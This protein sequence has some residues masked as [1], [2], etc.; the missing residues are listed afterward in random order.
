MRFFCLI[1][2]F[3]LVTY[4]FPIS[5]L[6]D[7]LVCRNLFYL[8]LS[9]YCSWLPSVVS[10]EYLINRTWNMGSFILIHWILNLVFV[11]LS[12]H[13]CRWCRWLYISHMISRIV[14]FI[15]I[16]WIYLWGYVGWYF[17]NDELN[18][19]WWVPKIYVNG[20]VWLHTKFNKI[21]WWLLG[22]IFDLDLPSQLWLLVSC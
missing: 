7:E 21:V 18:W 6:L 15:A 4:H 9:V 22:R 1:L 20:L 5:K 8:G 12:T 11:L 13:P 14:V 2:S 17:P 16:G 3:L 10:W 19:T